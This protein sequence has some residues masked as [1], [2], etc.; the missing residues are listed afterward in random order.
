[1]DRLPVGQ[2]LPAARISEGQPCSEQGRPLEEA[3][4]NQDRHAEL[5]V[6]THQAA[7]ACPYQVLVDPGAPEHHQVAQEPRPFQD[8]QVAHDSCPFQDRQ[9]D[10]EPCPFQGHQVVRAAQDAPEHHLGVCAA[11]EHLEAQKTRLGC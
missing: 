11:Q 9:V 1:M 3:V 7:L 8:R 2:P 6:H 5:V 4:R 10:Q